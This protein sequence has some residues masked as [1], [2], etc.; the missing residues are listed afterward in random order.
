MAQRLVAGQGSFPRFIGLIALLCLMLSGC[1]TPVGSTTWRTAPPLAGNWVSIQRGDTLGAIARRADVP[2]VR[3]LRF[4]PGVDPHKL[5][6]GQRIMVPTQQE[7]APSGGPYRYQVR[8]GDTYS[9][10]ARYFGTTPGRIQAAN[11]SVNPNTLKVGYLLHVPLRGDTPRV[12]S[13]APQPSRPATKPPARLPDP[14]PLPAQQK[15]WRWPLDDYRI[16]RQFGKDGRGS[17][18]PMLLSTQGGS[19]AKTV[20]SGKVSFANSMRHL[21]NVVIIHHPDNLQSV[22]ALCDDLK[23]KEGQSVSTGVAVCTVGYSSATERYDLLF[24]VRHGG[25][26]I[27]PRTVLR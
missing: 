26:P 11:R 16:V 17:L 19:Q 23:V 1:A 6:I 7:R 15:G 14:G 3:L 2:L 22:Y 13:R 20:A 9:S 24:D 5:A 25:K 27:D 18:Q 12:T 21:G 10:I 4:N 8:P